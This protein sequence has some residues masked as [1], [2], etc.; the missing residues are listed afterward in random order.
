[1]LANPEDSGALRKD[2]HYRGRGPDGGPEHHSQTVGRCRQV[3]RLGKLKS[4]YFAYFLIGTPA[5]T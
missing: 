1:M 4:T 5:S 3:R 2:G